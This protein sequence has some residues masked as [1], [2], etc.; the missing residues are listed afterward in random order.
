VLEPLYDKS[1]L[2]AQNQQIDKR[3][4]FQGVMQKYADV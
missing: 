2:F 4:F 1:V 3:L